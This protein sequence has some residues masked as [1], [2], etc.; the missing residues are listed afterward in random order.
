MLLNVPL[1]IQV[2]TP[3]RRE[4]STTFCEIKSFQDPPDGI[5]WIRAWPQVCISLFA[6]PDL[7]QIVDMLKGKSTQHS[8]TRYNK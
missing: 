3:S 2:L 4:V 6:V 1:V 7:K 8:Y 5:Y